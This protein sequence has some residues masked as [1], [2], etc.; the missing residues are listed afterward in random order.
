V[1]KTVS[2]S[3]RR[4]G[5]TPAGIPDLVTSALS[6]VSDPEHRRYQNRDFARTAELERILM[7]R[8]HRQAEKT[9]QTITYGCASRRPSW[10]F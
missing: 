3:N 5:E 6:G 4:S 9:L 8:A 2:G 10:N 1:L 7:R